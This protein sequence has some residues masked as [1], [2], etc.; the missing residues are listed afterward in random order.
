MKKVLFL[1]S[2]LYSGS[3]ALYHALNANP[4][5]QGFMNNKYNDYGSF[6]SIYTMTL[7]EHKCT[8]RAAIY[9]DELLFNPQLS[10]KTAYEFCKFIYVVR[11]PEQTLN[12]MISNNLIANSKSKPS[13]AVR[14]YTYRLRRICEMAKRTPG[15]VLLTFEDLKLGRGMDLLTDYLQLRQPVEFY[16]HYLQ[17][18]ERNFSTELLDTNLRSEVNDTYERYL[19]FLKNLSHLQR[20]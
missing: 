17:T 14:Y 5:I 6:L 12:L 1:A 16:P 18:L 19:Y 2:H 3:S 15:A 4:R 11:P 10:V 20:P 8:T 9:M 13:Y 7:Q